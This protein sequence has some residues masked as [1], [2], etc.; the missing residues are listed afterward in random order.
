LGPLSKPIPHEGSA[1]GFGLLSNNRRFFESMRTLKKTLAFVLAALLGLSLL[2][3]AALAAEFGDTAG[4]WAEDAI[5]TWA[6]H[7]VLNGTNGLFRPNAPITRAELAAVI[8]RVIGYNAAGSNAF[9]DVS[10]SDW[11]YGDVLRL[12]TAG[13]L[14]GSGGRARP[15]DN[16]TREEAA[17]VIARAF[18]LE[19]NA[20]GNDF[21]DA[22]SVSDWAAASVGALKA[23]GY[24]NGDN[25][26]RF[27]PRAN[28]T[29]AEVV[30]IIDNFI[31]AYYATAGEQTGS[32]T[33]NAVIR[34]DGVTLKD[35]TIG[36][37]LYIAEGVGEGTAIL[38]S[39]TVSGVTYIRGGGPNSV[40]I[41]GGT[42]LGRVVIVKPET[43][44]LR[45]AAEGTAASVES[46]AIRE[47]RS[48]VIF[49]GLFSRLS[50]DTAASVTLKNAKVGDI[51]V[52]GDDATVTVEA[53]ATADRVTISG[54]RV[55]L[56]GPGK[57]TAVS[58]TEGADVKVTVPNAAVTVS[59]TAGAVTTGNGV[60]IEPGKTGTSHPDSATPPSTGGSSSGGSGGTPSTPN[61]ATPAITAQP[62]DTP[63]TQ[64]EQATLTV[65]AFTSDGGTLSY[66]WYKATS[67]SSTAGGTLISG[68]TG[69]RYT[70]PTDTTGPTYYYVIVTNTKSG[71]NPATATSRVATV[72]VS[73]TPPAPEDVP[74]PVFT[75]QPQGAT[76]FTNDPVTLTVS[77]APVGDVVTQEFQWYKADSTDGAGEAI[78]SAIEST[79]AAPT[80]ETG[81]DYYYVVATNK[82]DD[83]TSKTATSE[84]AAVTVN[85]V[86]ATIAITDQPE[87]PGGLYVGHITAADTIGVT[88][89]F[90]SGSGTLRYQWYKAA[91]E[92]PGEGDTPLTEA[93][94]T[95]TYVLPTILAAG[96]H[97]YYVVVSADNARP[98]TSEVVTVTVEKPAI[99]ITTQPA[100]LTT[101][102]AGAASSPDRK[103]SVAATVTPLQNLSYQW[104]N[105]TGPERGENDSKVGDNAEYILPRLSAGEYYYYVEVISD[106]AESVYSDVVKVVAGVTAATEGAL[107]TALDGTDPIIIVSDNIELSSAT[108]IPTG[109]TLVVSADKTLTASDD[110]TVNGNLAVADGGTLTLAND[111]GALT[112][113]SGAELAVNGTLAVTEDTDTAGAGTITLADGATLAVTAL[114][115]LTVDGGT[116][117]EVGDVTLEGTDGGDGA[118]VVVNGTLTISGGK[119]L[120]V[121]ADSAKVALTIAGALNIPANA[122]LSVTENGTATLEDGA[123]LDVA[124][125]AALTVEGALALADDITLDTGTLSLGTG[126]KVVPAS[127]K[128]LTIESGAHLVAAAAG[129]QLT[130]GTVELE[131]GAVF[132]VADKATLTVAGTLKTS[133]DL[134]VNGTLDLSGG[135]LDIQKS[136]TL[137][138]KGEITV[139]SL[140]NGAGKTLTVSEETTLSGLTALAAD[141]TL[142]VN[143][144]LKLT[145]NL[146][147][148]IDGTLKVTDTGTLSAVKSEATEL[149]GAVTLEAGAT[150][151]LTTNLTVCQ[152]STLTLPATL[153]LLGAGTLSTTG[154]GT[155]ALP[156]TATLTVAK[157]ATPTI[158]VPPD[159]TSLTVAG[160][161]TLKAANESLAVGKTKSQSLTVS[162]N[163]WAPSVTVAA[164]EQPT[165]GG[166]L[167]VTDTGT[168]TTAALTANQNVAI[169]GTLT[170]DGSG[171]ASLT[172]A[173]EKTVTIKGKLDIQDSAS[174]VDGGKI[175]L[176]NATLNIAYEKSL[177]VTSANLE[178]Q[179]GLTLTGQGTLV[180]STNALALPN[181]AVLT[182]PGNPAAL[183][184]EAP[185][186]TPIIQGALSFTTLTINGDGN[187]DGILTLKDALTLAFDK[188][189]TVN[190]NLTLEK[191][192]T[193]DGTLRVTDAG[194]LTAKNTVTLNADTSVA[195]TLSLAKEESATL[196]IL[197]G[198]TL[199]VADG[200][201]L[202]IQTAVTLARGTPVPENNLP[203]TI[204]LTDGSTL[205]FDSTSLTL[206][207]NTALTLAGEVTLAGAGTITNTAGTLTAADGT[208]LTRAADDDDSLTI[209]D[210]L[211]VGNLTIARGAVGVGDSS[212]ITVAAGKTLTVAKGAALNVN[213][214]ILSAGATLT[215]DGAV[216]TNAIT[217]T[218]NATVAVGGALTVKDLTV[219]PEPPEEPA[220]QDAPSNITLTVGSSATLTITGALTVHT[221]LTIPTG[222]TLDVSGKDAT[223]GGAG[224]IVID[225]TFTVAE[226][227]GAFGIADLVPFVP[228]STVSITLSG[229]SKMS[230]IGESRTPLIGAWSRN[231]FPS[232]ISLDENTVL[233]ITEGNLVLAKAATANA[234]VKINKNYTLDDIL[235]VET[236]V[237]GVGRIEDITVT[238]SEHASLTV[239]QFGKDPLA[240]VAETTY[241]WD[242]AVWLPPEAEE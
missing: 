122:T 34:A 125:D 154:N 163:L 19:G 231:D 153:T 143:G 82:K 58:V 8:N 159:F 121:G 189:L 216:T 23:L 161:G 11:F 12:N 225:G 150:L 211:T 124:S 70:A 30:T 102:A 49:E 229:A 91:G 83:Q 172:I 146:T 37:D 191:A 84:R 127:G 47:S 205:A 187:G 199:T 13:V 134:T 100:G 103:L 239:K 240:I 92:E 112:I 44:V 80:A 113:A 226:D 118:D 208:S 224:K 190:G 64:G 67:A 18:G 144:T 182:I 203:G 215:I 197:G 20:G 157:G 106:G 188:S 73:G 50:V 166:T 133:E 72:T 28:I 85:A 165:G 16:L 137:N 86:T 107:I 142:L 169:A 149:T 54:D 25:A 48:G 111:G 160:E 223:I 219:G 232:C 193:V 57:V 105:P 242:G 200:G 207:A 183:S 76:V 116:S 174:L 117:L 135:T 145:D 56:T 104:Y 81:T 97:N 55:T 126:A 136:L 201:A 236:G 131:D 2:P 233:T 89:E 33:G 5:R 130:T 214:I 178:I 128:T 115:T 237:S 65:T 36:G 39:V 168:L 213:A 60:K 95:A 220:P 228:E 43:G 99:A 27:R 101:A 32:V 66:Q 62:Q 198:K 51:A 78:S 147:V 3:A 221:T 177:T 206:G 14:L 210:D 176:D 41:R 155:I 10:E 140:T 114:K 202:D 218:A 119:T 141:D 123:T 120:T 1:G 209:A 17:V 94:A 185:V 235:T 22:A 230:V 74:T 53:G 132:E 46:V 61:A 156:K 21:P 192:L 171:S 68:A 7:G 110:L 162:G 173:T 148:A 59:E 152:S 29:R 35:A 4:H 31:A 164:G 217:A 71:S 204:A 158:P 38:D 109:K 184:N 108:T 167:T 180:V 170:L 138:G 238:I 69:A 241:T 175:I 88:A 77:L 129:T 87:A 222:A 26:G 24:L 227:E 186:N 6:D 181:N 98:V 179:G 52:P 63:V 194:T 15:Q 196:T 75:T 195:G 45:L 40:I 42:R 212:E 90:T 96:S 79:Y 139:A 234:T 151:D 93:T 9:S